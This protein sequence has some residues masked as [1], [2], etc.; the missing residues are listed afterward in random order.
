MNQLTCVRSLSLTL[1]LAKS[2]GGQSV[3]HNTLEWNRRRK[4]NR[5]RFETIQ[6]TR[7]EVADAECVESRKVKDSVFEEEYGDIW[8]TQLY[9]VRE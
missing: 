5:W 7:K 6:M 9:V 1:N 8:G 4:M 3:K 2:G